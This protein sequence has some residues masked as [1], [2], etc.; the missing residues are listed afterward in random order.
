MVLAIHSGLTD[1]FE[2]LP[3]GCNDRIFYF[4]ALLPCRWSMAVFSLYAAILDSSK[5]SIR[6]L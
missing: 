5:E 2:Q 3:L 1:K 4:L 6:I